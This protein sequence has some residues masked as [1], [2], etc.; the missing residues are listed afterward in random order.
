MLENWLNKNVGP[1][2]NIRI[3]SEFKNWDWS[4]SCHNMGSIPTGIYFEREEDKLI[5]RLKFGI[6]HGREITD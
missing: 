5:F 1:Q 3:L 2:S 6:T 4:L